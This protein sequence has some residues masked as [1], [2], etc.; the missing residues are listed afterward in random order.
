M[1]DYCLFLF[2]PFTQC[3]QTTLDSPQGLTPKSVSALFGVNS[4]SL[5]ATTK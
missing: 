3:K 2:S 4:G 1:P 5:W